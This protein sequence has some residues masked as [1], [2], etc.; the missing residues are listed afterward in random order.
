M[1]KIK[2]SDSQFFLSILSFHNIQNMDMI[3]DQEIS[4]FLLNL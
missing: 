3:L 4:S 1:V 2:V